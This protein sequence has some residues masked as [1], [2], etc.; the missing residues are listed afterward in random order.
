MKHNADFYRNISDKK[1]VQLTNK[2]I[3]DIENRILIASGCGLYYI[4]VM[5]TDL[6]EEVV[7][8][9]KVNGFTVYANGTDTQV[10]IDWS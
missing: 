2:M 8:L 10:T 3:E 6:N 9:L 5:K 4:H 7:D 1:Y